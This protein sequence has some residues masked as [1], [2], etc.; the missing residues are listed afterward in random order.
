MDFLDRLRLTRPVV[1]A[2]MGGGLAT[3]ELAAAVSSAGGLGTVGI[4]PPATLEAELRTATACVA[5][6]PVAAN[7]IVPFLQRD[8]VEAVIRGGAKV[9][10]LSFG[11]RRSAVVA[12]RNAGVMVL[13]Q[14]GTVNE[15]RRALADGADGLIAQGI[16]A[17]GHLVGV[18]PT[19][20]FLPRALEVAAG[21]PVLAA[22]GIY[23][24]PTAAA[25]MS[26]GAAA[27]VAGTRFLLTDECHAHP[28]YKQRVCGATQTIE[29]TLF[30]L[31]WPRRHRVIP[32]A[33]T[34]R[35]L[36]AGREP[37]WMRLVCRASVPLG[38]LVPIDVALARVSWMP[39]NSAPV[40]AGQPDSAVDVSPLYAGECARNI[41][42][43]VP[44]AVA[45]TMLD[46]G[47]G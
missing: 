26:A 34:Q 13:H 2:G 10:V 17:G 19:L 16:E 42:A 35:W 6:R 11:F 24:R 3:S 36:R 22:G 41:H 25:A 18:E 31:G 32:N 28:R 27:V 47:A 38:R 9:A 40:L 15:A 37:R 30:G 46:Q 21:R 20:D 7:L 45:V 29:T 1:Q 44:A 14:V 5:P 23:D 4:L 12:L 33:A 39:P 8:H 43:I